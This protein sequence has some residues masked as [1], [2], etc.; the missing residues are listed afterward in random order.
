MWSCDQSLVALA[1]LSQPQFYKDLT[2][3]SNFFV[4]CLWFKFNNLGLGLGM[5]LKFCTSVVKVSVTEDVT[6]L[7]ST[8]GRVNVSGILWK[9][10]LS[11][12]AEWKAIYRLP[13]KSMIDSKSF[14]Y[15][16][17]LLY[18]LLEFDLFPLSSYFLSW[19]SWCKIH[20]PAVF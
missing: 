16:C 19:I 5:A 12:N 15:Q 17:K 11:F 3:K 7:T 1:F 14:I 8:M 6:C 10:F 2:R 9:W 18:H 13:T 20:S 4:G